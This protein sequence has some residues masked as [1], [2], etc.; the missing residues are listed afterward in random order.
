MCL[1][2]I[3][4]TISLESASLFQ[5]FIFKPEITQILSNNTS[6]Q[7]CASKNSQGD[8]YDSPD[9]DNNDCLNNSNL[10]TNNNYKDDY[11][12]YEND[13]FSTDKS[14]RS[15]STK[16]SSQEESEGQ[17][18]Q[19][20]SGNSWDEREWNGAESNEN[21]DISFFV[22]I[23]GEDENDEASISYEERNHNNDGYVDSR[24]VG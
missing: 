5:N 6:T 20:R 4:C 3:I 18:G 1:S 12:N 2:K 13:D 16:S 15:R 10:T 7:S 19:N 11:D 17:N 24:A 8:R 21:S 14:S 9:F 22:E 23:D